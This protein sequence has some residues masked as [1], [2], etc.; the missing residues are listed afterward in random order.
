MTSDTSGMQSNNR[1]AVYIL[2]K[3]RMITALFRE[4]FRKYSLSG[5]VFKV[6]V[7]QTVMYIT[8]AS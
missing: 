4:S 7:F 8:K 2:L 1:H 5:F 6:S 3:K